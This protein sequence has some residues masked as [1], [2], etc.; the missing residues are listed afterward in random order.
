MQLGGKGADDASRERRGREE[1]KKRREK[2]RK[3][4]AAGMGRG[5]EGSNV[6]TTTTRGKKLRPGDVRP[7]SGDCPSPKRVS[8]TTF[9]SCC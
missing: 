4:S 6:E 8:H 1:E 2:E 7:S 5:K 3:R 9:F